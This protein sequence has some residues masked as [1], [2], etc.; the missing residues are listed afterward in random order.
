MLDIKIQR[1]GTGVGFYCR[2][3]SNI[4]EIA[5]I[6]LDPQEVII[7]NDVLNKIFNTKYNISSNNIDVIIQ[8]V[9]SFI[10]EHEKYFV[11]L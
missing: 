7:H 3:D 5:V 9:I 8:V 6:N 11:F 10:K 2:F 1:F 4:D